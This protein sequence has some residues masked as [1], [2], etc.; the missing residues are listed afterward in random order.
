MSSKETSLAT[1]PTGVDSPPA[2]VKHGF[3]K[4]K[5]LKEVESSGPD[6]GA[7]V[8]YP[9]G[10]LRAWLVVFGVHSQA[11]FGLVFSSHFVGYVHNVHNVRVDEAS[12]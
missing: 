6:A 5:E 8:D 3:E 10:G 2:G 7:F 1:N 9:D 12:Q 11:Y 4:H